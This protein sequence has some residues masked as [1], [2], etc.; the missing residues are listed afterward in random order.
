MR[1]SQLVSSSRLRWPQLRISAHLTSSPKVAS[2]ELSASRHTVRGTHAATGRRYEITSRLADIW[3]LTLPGE[4]G[5]GPRSCVRG[6]YGKVVMSTGVV[7]D[8]VAPP[9]SLMTCSITPTPPNDT[10]RMSWKWMPEPVGVSNA[11]SAISEGSTL[12]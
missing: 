4:E 11:W 6:D 12:K 7:L 9:V 10:V 5:K 2:G 1:D 8:G 3:A